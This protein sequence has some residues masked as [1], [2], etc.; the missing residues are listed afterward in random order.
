MPTGRILVLWLPLV[1]ATQTYDV[2]RF[3]ARGDGDTKD[4]AAVEAALEA[5]SRQGGGVV[6]FPPGKYLCGTIHLKDNVTLEIS[7]GAVIL[8]SPQEKD[9]DPHE[10]L[11][12][13]PVDDRE[14]TYSRYALLAGEGVQNV[15]I[16]GAGVID[17]N[18]SRRGGPK[19][20]AFKNSRHLAIRGI[21][22]R[23]SP[24]YAVSFL[25]C[26]YVEL[27]GVKI[28]NSYADGIDPDCS[29]F[30]RI[31]N[32]YVD[33]HDDAICPK[34][35]QALG[36]PRPTEHLVVSHCILRTDCNAFKFGT[37][38]RGDLRNVAVTNCVLLPREGGR[39]PISGISLESVDGA[40]IRGVVISNVVMSGMGAAFFIRLG[41]RGR[42]MS[43][44][45][46]GSIEGV[47]LSNIVATGASTTSSVTGLPGRRVTDITLDN[48]NLTMTGGGEFR[49]LAVPELEDKYPEATMF[50]ELPACLLY[51]RHV[52]GL[53]VRN[54]QGRWQA[55]TERPAIILEDLAD[56]ELDGL[57]AEGPGGA[58]PLLWLH[59]VVGLS[60]RGARATRAVPLFLRVS[61]EQ[62]RDVMLWGNRLELAARRFQ[63]A[64]EVP[65]GAVREAAEPR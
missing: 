57:R 29:R 43:P 38:S 34:A 5:A 58:N 46:P 64:P 28:I 12:F 15:A 30:V 19:P 26:D 4:T 9:F 42:G 36:E 1:A 44:P 56:G 40:Q 25:G 54:F 3:G 32:C 55:P 37:E 48:I 33:S 52:Q 65:T 8:A 41:N 45:I 20:I 39:R 60:V 14:T 63:T 59:Q 22:V 11:P 31:S 17:G 2:R 27:E 50:G 10:T 18:R 7:A 16:T 62:S 51:A 49:G 61:G 23:N 24:N 13:K 35:S 47:V 6:V 53:T 21:T